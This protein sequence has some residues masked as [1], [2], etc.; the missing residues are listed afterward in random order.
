MPLISSSL[1]KL[2]EQLASTSCQSRPSV[3]ES[4]DSGNVR[5]RSILKMEMSVSTVDTYLVNKENLSTHQEVLSSSSLPVQ[6]CESNNSGG[7]LTAVAQ[8][9]KHAFKSFSSKLN[10]E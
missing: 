6:K 5:R 10:F 8:A 3:A 2:H 4:L 7:F 1:Q 9:M